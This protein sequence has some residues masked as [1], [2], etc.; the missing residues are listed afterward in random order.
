M[1][2]PSSLCFELAII[3]PKHVGTR[4]TQTPSERMTPHVHN[5]TFSPS[6]T[7][8]RSLLLFSHAVWLMDANRFSVVEIFSRLPKHPN[9]RIE[10]VQSVALQNKDIYH[11]RERPS[12]CAKGKHQ[13]RCPDTI[14]ALVFVYWTNFR[15]SKKNRPHERNPTKSA[16]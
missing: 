10:E 2:C 16:P 4:M 12:V 5:P 1:C 7:M 6:A 9:M 8:T 14:S 15:A 13:Q 11:Q 3:R